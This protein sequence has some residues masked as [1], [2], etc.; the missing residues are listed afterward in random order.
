MKSDHIRSRGREV[1]AEPFFSFFF[2]VLQFWARL[3]NMISCSLGIVNLARQMFLSERCLSIV[4][5]LSGHS[6][7]TSLATTGPCSSN[8][9]PWRKSRKKKFSDD[10]LSS[11]LTWTCYELFVGNSGT[12]KEIRL[13]EKLFVTQRLFSSSESQLQEKQRVQGFSILA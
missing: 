8:T 10:F 4:L 1:E 5:I 11:R 9:K 12:E 7:R 6:Y 3:H 2:F 13:A